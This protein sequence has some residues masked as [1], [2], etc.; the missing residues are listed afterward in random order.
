MI[1]RLVRAFLVIARQVSTRMVACAV[2]ITVLKRKDE[3]TAG[4]VHQPRLER[5]AVPL[6]DLG[7]AS[8]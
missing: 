8:G 4:W 2:F 6:N 7:S 3:Q 5:G 1:A